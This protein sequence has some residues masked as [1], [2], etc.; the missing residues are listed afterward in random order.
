MRRFLLIFAAATALLSQQPPAVK[1]APATTI[2]ATVDVV[3]APTTVIDSRG[4]V[5]NGLKPHE[6]RLYDNDKL[7][8]V[9]EDIGFLPL[10]VVVCIQANYDTETILPKIKS[11]APVLRDLLIGQDGELAILGFD[12]R[13]QTLTEFTNDSEQIKAALNKLRVGSSSSRLKDAT[14]Q[15]AMMLRNK[16]DR[17]KVVLLISETRDIASE[18]GIREVA[19]MLQ[20][21]NIDV[22]TVNINT[23]VARLTT[24]PSYP[25]PSAIPTTSMP[26]PGPASKDPTSV[27][28]T[29]GSPGY[30]MEMAPLFQEVFM[31]V[32]GL[33][34]NNPSEAFTKMTGG[35]E[36]KFINEAQLQ[37]D[38]S[39]IGELLHTQYLLSYNPNNKLEG[40][41]HKI[42]VEVLRTG[43]KV[44][45]RP[46]YWMAARPE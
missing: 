31:G 37:N 15:A 44:R 2:R 41:F 10:S 5:V 36:F 12:H 35:R 7:Q 21:Y 28:Q 19:T 30:A 45:T 11:I 26:M 23:W 40:G 17:R 46:G 33:F 18:A 22:Y 34:V 29:W 25:R 43:L 4:Q 38:I 6:F 39:S 16:K 14:L 27:A 3:I 8:E 1:D 9:T 13:I 42:H 24:K 20:M 32:K